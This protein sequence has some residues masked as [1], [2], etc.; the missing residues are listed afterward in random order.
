MPNNSLPQFLNTT[1]VCIYLLILVNSLMPENFATI[2]R[3]SLFCCPCP[4]NFS[5][6]DFFGNNITYVEPEL[7]EIRRLGEHRHH[8]FQWH[9]LLGGPRES[10]HLGKTIFIVNIYVTFYYLISE[11]LK[12][13][14]HWIFHIGQWIIRFFWWQW[15]VTWVSGWSSKIFKGRR[16][17]DSIIVCIIFISG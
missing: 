5:C 16:N 8:Y 10:R 1:K 6:C 4:F 15:A 17:F 3:S 14:S 7:G 2:L 13:S 9:A 11:L 12:L